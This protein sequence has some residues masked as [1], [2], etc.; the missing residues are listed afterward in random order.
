MT[1]S[2]IPSGEQSSRVGCFLH[3]RLGG[4]KLKTQARTER[5]LPVDERVPFFG[6]GGMNLHERHS[7]SIHQ[8]DRDLDFSFDNVA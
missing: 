4:C 7:G 3:L 6:R 5:R 1:W 2:P 8:C